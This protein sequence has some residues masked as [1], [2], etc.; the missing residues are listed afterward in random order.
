MAHSFTETFHHK[1]YDGISPIKPSLLAT[2]K[3]VVIVGGYKDIG[4]AVA[5]AYA[6]A[7]ASYIILVSWNEEQ[8]IKAQ[9]A[10]KT[11]HQ[12]TA[13]H[14]CTTDIT[15]EYDVIFAFEAIRDCIR[16]PDILILCAAH[17]S[18]RKP[19]LDVSEDEI[20]RCFDFD[21]KGKMR[22]VREFLKSRTSIV[23]KVIINMSTMAA[24][25]SQ[26]DMSVY[27]A[28]RLAFAHQLSNV[29][30]E[31][32]GFVRVHN[33]HPGITSTDLLLS[34][35]DEENSE[36]DDCKSTPSFLTQL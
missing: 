14:Y 8:L 11:E 33:V 23:Q 27:G 7:K 16:E 31:S 30:D 29:H 13:V 15:K 18:I 10:L 26:L 17:L 5:K 1:T 25:V 9:E 6:A 22:L 21:V 19:V 3:A 2:G 12:S 4:Y 36:E 32:C 24:H 35:L 20:D 28:V 34:D